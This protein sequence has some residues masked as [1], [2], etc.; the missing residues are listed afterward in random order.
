MPSAKKSVVMRTSLESS[1]RASLKGP[2]GPFNDDEDT[3]AGSSAE[4][5]NSSLPRK[6]IGSATIHVNE[7]QFTS[8]SMRKKKHSL[9]PQMKS[10]RKRNSS[11]MV[12][13]E[14]V[15]VEKSLKGP[16]TATVTPHALE[17]WLNATLV[18]ATHM[19]IPGVITRPEHKLPTHRYNIDRQTL[20]NA[21]ISTEEVDRIYRMLFVHSV[22]YFELLKKIL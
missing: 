18:D 17:N 7:E 10:E 9:G 20:V 19:E 3:K 2:L 15:K 8:N 22:G 14:D 16:S 13:S 4:K 21:G 11:A 1:K 5:G 12:F 6:L